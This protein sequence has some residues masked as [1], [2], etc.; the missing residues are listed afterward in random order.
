MVFLVIKNKYI[1]FNYKSFKVLVLVL[2]FP[3]LTLTKM[4]WLKKTAT[5]RK[6]MGFVSSILVFY[7]LH[8]FF[9]GGKEVSSRSLQTG[10]FLNTNMHLKKFS[11]RRCTVQLTSAPAPWSFYSWAHL[12]TWMILPGKKWSKWHSVALR[13][14]TKKT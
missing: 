11:S 8:F 1:H 6:N 7:R 4:A 13:Q 12:H 2:L 14:R 9:N 3:F 5:L 10:Q